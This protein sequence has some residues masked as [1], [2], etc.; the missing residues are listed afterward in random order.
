MLAVIERL[1]GMDQSAPLL[2]GSLRSRP[3][4]VRPPQP[5]ADWLMPTDGAG[6]RVARTRHWAVPFSWSFS[7]LSNPHIAVIGMSGSGKSFF[8]KTFLTRANVSFG[9]RAL[10]I[11]WSGEYVPWVRQSGGMV[12]RLGPESLN[13]LD[14]G[15]MSPSMR[16]SQV[17]DSLR[18]LTDLKDFPKERQWVRLAV[19]MAYALGRFSPSQ[20]SSRR[21]PTLLDV[22]AWLKLQAKK[23]NLSERSVVQSAYHLLR[24][25]CLPGA[26][27]F[28][29]PTSFRLDALL[30]SGLS[31]VDLSGLPS[32][33]MRSLA[34]LCIVQFVREAMRA[35]G[36]CEGRNLDLMVVMDEA[37]KICQE[38]GDPVAIVREGRKYAFGLMVASQ[39]PTD[40]SPVIFSN[41]GSLFVFRTPFSDSLDYLQRSLRFG[42]DVRND[43]AQLRQGQCAVALQWADHARSDLF[44]LER[45]DGEGLLQWIVLEGTGMEW[46]LE[47][48][49]VFDGLRADGVGEDR[50]AVLDSFLNRRNHVVD[51]AHFAQALQECGLSREAIRQK[52]KT[53]GLPDDQVA[54]A[55]AGLFALSLPSGKRLAEL[56][57][58]P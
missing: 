58:V 1:L 31:C 4:F 24:P 46:A 12:V 20:R 5:K 40:L 30:K 11:D 19:E 51:A 29:R 43:L 48:S 49:A 28:A 7:P 50:L 54:H 2:S 44:F 13:L 53:A 10:I 36:P 22:L 26:D 34:G 45:V 38:D 23:Q 18:L 9:T 52:F 16:T 55:M 17:V 27:F 56:V 41:V 6:V 14:L 21:A 37:W 42:P 35:R 3:I 32:E 47:K 57:L 8:V 33:S 15:G 25:L 39:N